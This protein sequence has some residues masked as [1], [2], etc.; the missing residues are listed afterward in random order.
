MKV[1]VCSSQG[2]IV[3]VNDFWRVSMMTVPS[4]GPNELPRPPTMSIP[5]YNIDC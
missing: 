3:L 5:M 2:A 1:I 4:I